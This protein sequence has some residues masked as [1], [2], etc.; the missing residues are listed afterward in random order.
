ML[1]Y[2]GAIALA[3]LPFLA[4]AP[5]PSPTWQADLAHC[6]AEFTVSHM[7]VSKVWGHVP[8]R[9]LTIAGNAG[10]AVPSKLDATLDPAHEDTDNHERDAD[11]RSPVY[12]DTAQYPTMVFRSTSIVPKDAKTFTVTGTLTIKNVTKTITFPV[13]IVGI[14]P[15]GP[16]RFRVGYNAQLQIDRRDYGLVDTRLTAAGVLLVGYTV[17]IGLTVEATT[18]DP[19]L[20]ATTN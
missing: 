9:A 8:V 13:Q 12:F 11:L 10:T 6:R 20:H 5:A 2:I 1:S 18:N 19:T 16:G 7:V 17:D 4:A 14:I 15:D 3:T